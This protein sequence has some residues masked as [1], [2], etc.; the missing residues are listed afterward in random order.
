MFNNTSKNKP[1]TVTFYNKKKCGVDIVDQMVRQY[2]VKAVTR[3]Q[4]VAVFYNNLDL[5]VI[6]AYHLF[7][8]IIF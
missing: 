1:E 6:N 2:M 4:P 7:V 8:T 5:A 3:K